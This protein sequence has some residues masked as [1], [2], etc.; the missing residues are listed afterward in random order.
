MYLLDDTM[1]INGVVVL[2]NPDETIFKNISSYI[3]SIDKLYVIDNSENKNMDIIKKIKIF[4]DKCEYID[5]NGNQGIANALNVGAHLAIEDEAHWLLTMDQDSRFENNDIKE[6]IDFTKNN[7]TTQIGIV[8]PMHS[9]NEVNNFESNFS[10]YIAMTSG[11]LL[12]LNIYQKIGGFEEKL[13]IDSVDI[14]YCLKL[15]KNNF[16]LQRIKKIILN[17]NLGNIQK[18]RFYSVTNHNYIRRYYITRNR[19]YIW[20]KYKEILPEYIKY[21]KYATLKEVVKIILG[22]KDKFKKLKMIY[23]GYRDYKIDR[24]GKYKEL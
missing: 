18:K 13:F 17:H 8:S 24:Y 1:V 4:S 10:T 15:Y 20:E 21:E 5:N 19:L 14:E 6:L 3:N 16:F 7:D 12:N 11:N 9:E 2:Y 22:E 23:K